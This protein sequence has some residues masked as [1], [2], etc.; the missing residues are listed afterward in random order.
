MIFPCG[1]FFQKQNLQQNDEPE[2]F[3][4]KDCLRVTAFARIY[5]LRVSGGNPA[6]CITE[7]VA[8]V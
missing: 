5:A 4:I 8:P 3:C 1:I 6:G 7:A 2:I